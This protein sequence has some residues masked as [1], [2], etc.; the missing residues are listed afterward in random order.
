MLKKRLIAS[1][2]IKDGILVQSINF[3]KYLPIGDPKYT[4]ELISRWDVDEIVL[5]DISA[6][7]EK[8]IISLEVLNLV[9][10]YCF[11][12]L[13]VGGGIKSID[14]VQSI[15][16]TGADKIVINS[17]CI[18]NP[19]LITDISSKFG[20][21]CVVVSIDCKKN[22]NG[23]YEVYSDSGTKKSNLD[24]IEW[25]KIAES[26]GAGEILL[27]SIDR[28]GTKQGYD[29]D[30]ISSI[31]NNVK[32]P[33]IALGG[34]GKFSHFAEGIIDGNASAVGAANIFHFIEHSTIVAKANLLRAGIDIRLDSE[35]SYNDREFDSFGRFITYSSDR[36]KDI[37]LKPSKKRIV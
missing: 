25:S 10:K 30:L 7:T 2:I 14:D 4:V 29:I 18:F 11:V 22:K 37:E 34:V 19:K 20:N 13:T 36:L 8:R 26:L 24:P 17:E 3:N 6:R 35:A 16:S 27:N 28:D 15:I 5:L 21:Q 23:S 31:S 32:I 9:S 33:V 12:P 1:L